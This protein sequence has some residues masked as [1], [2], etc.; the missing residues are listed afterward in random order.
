MSK[1]SRIASSVLSAFVLGAVLFSASAGDKSSLLVVPAKPS[2][3][4][5]CIDVARMTPG[6][7]L[8]SYEAGKKTNDPALTM[9]LWNGANESWTKITL[10]E[11]QSGSLFG[12]KPEGVVLVETADKVV[13]E[14]KA[15]STVFGSIE[16][17]SKLD[18]MGLANGLNEIYAFPPSH[19][20][21]LANRYE[22]KLKDLNA[23]RRRYGKYGP[24][25][26]SA[27]VPMPKVESATSGKG[28]VPMDLP[29]MEP[30]VTTEPVKIT[31]PENK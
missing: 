17:V 8:V 14:V 18:T 20:K 25:G 10:A 1:R 26:G 3:Q 16:T 28:P 2:V 15:A 22:L 29:P 21:F 12:Q 31:P 9:R 11:Y 19:W 5:F 23:V 6:V 27:A 24:P 30:V 4:N 13:A 7:I